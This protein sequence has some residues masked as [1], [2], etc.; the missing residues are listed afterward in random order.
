VPALRR[1]M[2]RKDTRPVSR[3]ARFGKLSAPVSRFVCRSCHVQCRPLLDLLG[4]EPVRISGCLARL[5]ALMAAVAPY[6]LAARLAWLLL[7]VDVNAMSVWRAAQ[8]LDLR[9]QEKL[10]VHAAG[11][12]L[13]P[14][15]RAD[16]EPVPFIRDAEQ[17]PFRLP[18]SRFHRTT[19][20]VNPMA[21]GAP[22]V[23]AN[24]LINRPCSRR[25]LLL[26]PKKTSTQSESVLSFVSKV[27]G[28][29]L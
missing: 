15:S 26:Y 17:R 16:I 11:V 9:Y 2:R 5:P 18:P 28:L 4:V 23:I 20:M 6:S 29:L 25:C 21:E 7:G 19:V 24:A 1:I 27:G 3:L 10:I 13:P 14:A 12:P 8:R 22:N